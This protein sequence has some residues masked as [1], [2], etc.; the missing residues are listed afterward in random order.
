[1]E[2]IEE[3][4]KLS[5]PM[6]TVPNRKGSPDDQMSSVMSECTKYPTYIAANI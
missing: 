2:G 6:A 4:S 1:M 5:L 3:Q